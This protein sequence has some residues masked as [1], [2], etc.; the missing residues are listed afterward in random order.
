MEDGESVKFVTVDAAMDKPYEL[1]GHTLYVSPEYF[2]ILIN[3]D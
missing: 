2:Q 3:E 1:V